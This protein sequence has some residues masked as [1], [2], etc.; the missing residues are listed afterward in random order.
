MCPNCLFFSVQWSNQSNKTV[1]L[2]QKHQNLIGIWS[3]CFKRRMLYIYIYIDAN[4]QNILLRLLLNF[5]DSV[6]FKMVGQR[7]KLQ[8]HGLTLRYHGYN[9]NAEFINLLYTYFVQY[10]HRIT[11]SSQL[12]IIINATC[13]SFSHWFG[14]SFECSVT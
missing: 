6:V 5:N 10:K 12:V 8:S 4:I 7:S 14:W 13:S 2:Q 9:N 11:F 3:I 1:T